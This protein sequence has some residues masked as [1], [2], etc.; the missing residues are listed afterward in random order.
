MGYSNIMDSL[1][2]NVDKTK[3]YPVES[4]IWTCKTIY[5]KNVEQESTIINIGIPDFADK[6]ILPIFMLFCYFPV[7][8]G[9]RCKSHFDRFNIERHANIILLQRENLFSTDP[10]FAIVTDFTGV[11]PQALLYR[12]VIQFIY[13]M[14]VLI[15]VDC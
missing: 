10:V 4:K 15:V 13:Q 7:F 1:L 9:T 6:Y 3:H 12:I 2:S 8:Y 14:A 5:H 11:L